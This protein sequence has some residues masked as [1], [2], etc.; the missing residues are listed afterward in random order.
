MKLIIRE[1]GDN[2]VG[3]RDAYY[4][5]ECPF[6]KDVEEE[7]LEFFRKNIEGIYREFCEGKIRAEY[8]FEEKL[9]E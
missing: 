1:Y 3:I 5:V 9:D 4:E 2:S 8:D 7:N 6:E